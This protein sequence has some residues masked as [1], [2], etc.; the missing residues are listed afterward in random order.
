LISLIQNELT[1]IF[2]KK[3]IYITLFITLI[4]IIVINVI[5]VNSNNNYGYDPEQ[6]IKFYE[7][8]LEILQED[9]SQS[10]KEAISMYQ[11]E[12]DSAKL[13]QKYGDTA[14]WQASIIYK[15]IRPMFMEKNEYLQTGNKQ[16]AQEVQIQIE[17]L[18]T[19]LDAGDWRYF[20]TQEL[21]EIENSIQE[22]K[23][24]KENTT[25]TDSIASIED[26]IFDLNLQ[27][28][29]VNWRLEKDIPY[30]YS[31]WNT[32]LINYQDAQREIRD[33]ER[34]S[35]QDNYLAKQ[36]YYHSL[37]M[38]AISQYDIE[39]KVESGNSS[40]ARGLLL[41]GCSQ[42]EL[43]IIIMIIMVTGT[44]VSEEFNKGTIKL[45]LIKPYKRSTILASKWITSLIMLIIIIISILLMQLVVG[46]I[47]QGFD[48]F[49]TPAIVYDHT[50]DQIG[51]MNIIAYL[52]M[53]ILGKLPIYI[54]LM[55]LAFAF[56]T[57][58]ANSALA[59]TITLLGYMGAPFVNTIA[60]AYNLDWI[61]FFV[62]PNWDL[63]QYFFGGLPEFQGLTP[64][65]SIGIIIVYMLIM[66]IPTFVFF[67]KKNIKNI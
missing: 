60:Q 67:K 34:S 5:Y 26:Q 15:Q 24:L 3:S 64:I 12:I 18:V 14:T 23:Q 61:K 37:E 6:D 1:K 41:N 30:G 59:I 51:E 13:V 27:K 49:D 11:S 62:T 52:I 39:H 66:L 65:F 19:K 42:F 45:L 22:Q 21:Q 32:C 28:Q 31:Y 40:N 54:L 43:F 56:S 38:S 46:G 33:Y 48:T 8:Q 47:V 17:E 57:I 63:T 55:T 29:V 4:F 35:N 7:S 53:Q 20:A 2:K 50:T 44:I 10:A 9:N 25:N 16:A 58:F 36:S